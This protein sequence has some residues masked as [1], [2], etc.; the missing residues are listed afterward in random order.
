VLAYMAMMFTLSSIPGSTLNRLGF[1]PTWVNLAHL[2]LFAGLAIVT[3]WALEGTAWLRAAYAGVLC[4]AFAISDE[5]HQAFVPGRRWSS[6]DLGLDAVGILLGL[7][8]AA[9]FAVAI[10]SIGKGDPGS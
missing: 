3:F 2:P 1:A 6:F 4:A 10:P 9:L 5:W 7:S 8:L